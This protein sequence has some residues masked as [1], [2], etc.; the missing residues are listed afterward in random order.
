MH[1]GPY[2]E[3]PAKKSEI[4]KKNVI[5]RPPEVR[6]MAILALF[7]GARAGKWLEISS[8]GR[9]YLEKTKGSLFSLLLEVDIFCLGR[10]TNFQSWSQILVLKKNKI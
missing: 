5:F 8:N 7:A 9:G 4:S 3:F 10:F 6:K 2:F 1:F